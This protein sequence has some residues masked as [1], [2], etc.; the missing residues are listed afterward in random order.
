MGKEN[1]DDRVRQQWPEAYK[2]SE[3]YKETSGDQHVGA[4]PCCGGDDRFWIYF[5]GPHVTTFGCRGCEPGKHTW[6]AAEIARKLNDLTGVRSATGKWKVL[7]TDE[8]RT[9][10]GK[11]RHVKA[12]PPDK[13]SPKTFWQHWDEGTRSWQAKMGAVKMRDLLWNHWTVKPDHK[14]CV[15][16]EG[17]KDASALHDLLRKE[18]PDTCFV[19]G[20]GGAGCPDM[21]LAPLSHIKD[22]YVLFDADESGR[23]GSVKYAARI[24]ETYPNARIAHYAPPGYSKEDWSDLIEESKSSNPDPSSVMAVVTERLVESMTKAEVFSPDS[25]PART[26][27][28]TSTNGTLETSVQESGDYTDDTI[29]LGWTDNKIAGWILQD[30]LGGNLEDGV[31]KNVPIVFDESRGEW[32]FCRAGVWKRTDVPKIVAYFMAQASEILTRGGGGNQEKLLRVLESNMK[33][34]QV[35][36]IIQSYV[37][38]RGENVFDQNSWLVCGCPPEFDPKTIIG[39]PMGQDITHPAK[40]WDL[41]TGQLRNAVPEDCIR[42]TLGV[43][44]PD[45][46]LVAPTEQDADTLALHLAKDCPEF[47]KLL[48]QISSYIPNVDTPGAPTQEDRSWM[49]HMCEWIGQ[50][51]S[52]D[53]TPEKF[54]FF[55]GEGSNGKG[56]LAEILLK[57]AGSVGHIAPDGLFK[58][59]RTAHRQEQAVL[60]GKHVLI[61]DELKA[62]IDTGLLKSWT[63]GMSVTAD[64]KGGKSITFPVKFTV[65]L[66]SNEMPRFP[67]ANEAMRRRLIGIPFDMSFKDRD[68]P[69][70]RPGAEGGCSVR[71]AAQPRISGC[72]QRTMV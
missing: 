33:R 12:I 32:Y 10:K 26:P 19:S 43:A 21:N 23:R 45:R 22:F 67:S 36:K 13:S 28:P 63:G 1:F 58:P 27:A 5:R 57:L 31:W 8:Y 42:S 20:G 6:Q 34:E 48:G 11:V 25:L 39:D 62:R 52:A 70:R 64:H 35:V 41:N 2:N 15:V 60:E 4:C 53:T 61:A 59:T 30:K 56:L 71:C 54:L 66:L 65:V 24:H 69:F 55:T 38:E 29:P 18:M 51:L 16:C 7:R 72:C 49:L 44:L 50:C 37:R 17:E 68:R 46:G 14:I 47:W 3:Y 40:V 9:R